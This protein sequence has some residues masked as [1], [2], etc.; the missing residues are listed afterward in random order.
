ML[1]IYLF[2]VNYF[3]FKYVIS[4]VLGINYAYKYRKKLIIVNS[5]NL[6]YFG[7]YRITF[8][9]KALVQVCVQNKHKKTR[10]QKY[11]R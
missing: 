6:K 10:S 11:F 2:G 3:E 9:K 1:E 4:N 5:C 7:N 8:I